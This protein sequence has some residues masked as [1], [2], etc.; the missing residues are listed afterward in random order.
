MLVYG[1]DS[2]PARIALG[3][4][5]SLHEFQSKV[6]SLIM[7]HASPFVGSVRSQCVSDCAG[8]R[9]TI[10][11]RMNGELYG[12]DPPLPAMIMDFRQTKRPP[13]FERLVEVRA[14]NLVDVEAICIGGTVLASSVRLPLH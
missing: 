1:H 2:V 14:Q 10:N 7:P 8:A 3:R 9:I 6:V 12:R 4:R 13:P 11:Q 5:L